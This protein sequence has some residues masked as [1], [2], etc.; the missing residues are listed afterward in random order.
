MYILFVAY[1]ITVSCKIYEGI[2]RTASVIQGSLFEK[3]IDKIVERVGFFDLYI[4][5]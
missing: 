3:Y 5:V 2:F 4:W 1:Q